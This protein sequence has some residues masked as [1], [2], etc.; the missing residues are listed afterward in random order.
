M[1]KPWPRPPSFAA[2]TGRVLLLVTII[3]GYVSG[4]PSSKLLCSSVKACISVDGTNCTTQCPPCITLAPSGIF[5]C[6]SRV[7]LACP[8]TSTLS[9]DGVGIFASNYSTTVPTTQRVP[10]NSPSTRPPQSNNV[11]PTS[12]PSSS[13]SV[14]SSPSITIYLAIAAAVA[15]LALCVVLY[16]QHKSARQSV[17]S[18]LD[19]PNPQDR[20]KPPGVSSAV[21][22]STVASHGG[23]VSGPSN[24]FF[25]VNN[26]PTV[27][28]NDALESSPLSVTSFPTAS[29]TGFSHSLVQQH[30]KHFDNPSSSSLSSVF[31]IF[32]MALSPAANHQAKR[33]T[34]TVV[35][36]AET[37]E[38]DPWDD[39][40]DSRQLQQQR[41]RD[42][43]V[44][45][46]VEGD[47]EEDLF[48]KDVDTMRASIITD[49]GGRFSDC[50]ST[51]SDIS[52][53]NDFKI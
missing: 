15:V 8:V 41:L 1:L 11:S 6:V 26:P 46:M 34:S 39:N 5:A 2:T 47:D 49:D 13:D 19:H 30:P 24:A 50:S 48:D 44:V 16:C 38:Y 42:S 51:M 52:D 29:S 53:W 23:G 3:Q 10:T 45:M 37:M 17:S 40:E 31:S 22:I 4:Q 14:S 12:T 33:V 28:N 27:G 43:S 7:G 18:P 9:C 25:R 32:H 21:T 35:E 20:F 36:L